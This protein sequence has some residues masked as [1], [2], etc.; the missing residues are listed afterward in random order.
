MAQRVSIIHLFPYSQYAVVDFKGEYVACSHL[1]V[2]EGETD[3]EP[4]IADL[5]EEKL[6]FWAWGHYFQNDLAGALL[7]AIKKEEEAW[8]RHKV[9]L[10]ESV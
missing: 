5:E 7:Y 9:W 1:R 3:R 6:V 10:E 4:I 8:N 2:C